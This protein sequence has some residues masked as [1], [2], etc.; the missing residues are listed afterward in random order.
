MSYFSISPTGLTE[1]PV[2]AYEDWDDVIATVIEEMTINGVPFF[3][4]SG[5]FWEPD[6][7]GR[8]FAK[9][10]GKKADEN[11][12]RTLDIAIQENPKLAD[13]LFSPV[14]L[15]FPSRWFVR[16]EVKPGLTKLE[17]RYQ[18]YLPKT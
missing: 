15:T 10:H 13:K 5:N 1:N 7:V 4:V 12:V 11:W 14:T 17:K 3:R 18:H 16:C 9:G 2:F 8:F 6:W